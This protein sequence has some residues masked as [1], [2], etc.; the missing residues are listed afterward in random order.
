MRRILGVVMALV[1]A[2]PLWAEEAKPILVLDSGGHTAQVTQVLFTSDG[3]ELITVSD[4]KTIRFWDVA[5]GEP[6][7]VLR[8]PIGPGSDGMLYAAALSPDGATLAV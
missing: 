1:A 5:S 4:D 6:L 8:P 7:R 3:K 2:A